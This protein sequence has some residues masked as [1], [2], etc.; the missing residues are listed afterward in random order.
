M[1]EVCRGL[2]MICPPQ[3]HAFVYVAPNCWCY[4][5][6]IGEVLEVGPQL[7]EVNHWR[8]TS[9]ACLPSSVLLSVAVNTQL[10]HGPRD[11]TKR[12]G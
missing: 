11:D 3:T 1:V 7:E 9:P 6:G 8:L 12:W 2:D 5:R 10:Q 4:F